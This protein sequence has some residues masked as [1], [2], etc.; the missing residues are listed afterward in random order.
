M[1][2]P[3]SSLPRLSPDQSQ[4]L[5]DYSVVHMQ[6]QVT[7]AA[8]TQAALSKLWDMAFDGGDPTVAFTRFSYGAVQLIQ[9]ARSRGQITATQ[10]YQ[11]ARDIAGITEDFPDVGA[12][13]QSTAADLAAIYSTASSS[14]RSSVAAG[15][16]QDQAL[17]FAKAAMLGAAK[18]RILQASRQRILDMSKADRF[19]QRWA[20]VCDGRPC[21]FCAMLASRGAVYHSESTA[22]FQAHDHCGC[23]CMPVFVND[24]SHG[25]TDLSKA[26]NNE[27]HSMGTSSLKDWR[28]RY[29]DLTSDP[30]SSVSKA[31]TGPATS[32]AL[33][34]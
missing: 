1:D 34:A 4:A 18:R 26:L 12:V 13:P 16:S 24:P 19:S 11:T 30:A 10:Y 15:Q 33:A 22:N 29:S 28:S 8:Q 23:S 25:W 2:S 17:A 20:R 6:A 27:W 31:L 32:H 21:Y 3:L 5:I 14:L 9:A 7:Q